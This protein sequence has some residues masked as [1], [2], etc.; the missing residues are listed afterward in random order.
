MKAQTRDL[1][2][3]ASTASKLHLRS[4]TESNARRNYI[5]TYDD[6]PNMAHIADEHG[7]GIARRC[8]FQFIEHRK[9][10]SRGDVSEKSTRTP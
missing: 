9:R 6:A 4:I 8:S 2:L 1:L 10:I 3:L 5:P 7:I